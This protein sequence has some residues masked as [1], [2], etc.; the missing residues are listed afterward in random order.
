MSGKNNI[1][2]FEPGYVSLATM[3]AVSKSIYG[4][5]FRSNLSNIGVETLIIYGKAENINNFKEEQIEIS[6]LLNNSTLVEFEKSGH[7]CFLEEPDMFKE[8]ILNFLKV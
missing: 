5:D 8:I 6:N 7:W 4:Y 1:S 2:L 3:N